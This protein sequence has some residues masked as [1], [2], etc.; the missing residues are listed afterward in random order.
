VSVIGAIDG[1]T[2]HKGGNGDLDVA[3]STAN[4]VK[5]R[6]RVQVHRLYP[7]LEEA[8]EPGCRS[9]LG[10]NTRALSKG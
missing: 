2:D 3:G 8:K 1:I 6:L 9:R 7:G 10:L 5:L 4:S